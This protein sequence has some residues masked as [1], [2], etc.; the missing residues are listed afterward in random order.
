M[1]PQFTRHPSA[2][3]EWAAIDWHQREVTMNA[4]ARVYER[5]ERH[6][7][8]LFM[9][10][11]EIAWSDYRVITNCVFYRDDGIASRSL[12]LAAH[13]RDAR[14]AKSVERYGAWIGEALASHSASIQGMLR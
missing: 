10:E 1:N 13:K 5:M 4:A 6:A 7:L 8:G 3:S 12:A 2:V 11:V 9:H 14:I